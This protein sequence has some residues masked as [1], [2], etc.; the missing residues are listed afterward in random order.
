MKKIN[1][2]FCSFPDYSGNA[3]GLYEYIIKRNVSNFNLVWIVYNKDSVDKLKQIGIYAI[4]IGTDEFKEYISTTDIFF[5]THGNLTGDKTEKSLYVELWHGIGPKPIG[6]MTKNMLAQ[7]RVWYK[8]LEKRIDYFVTP[9]QFW[10]VLFSSM[11]GVNPDRVLPLG[12]PILDHI[13]NADG[14]K[15]LS[16]VLDTEV[17]KYNKIIYYLPTFRKGC[18]RECE[19]NINKNNIFNFFEYNE[20]E[21]LKYLKDNN[22]LLVL[23]R[24]PSEELKFS[25]TENENFHL[26]T[27]DMLAE[28]G[29]T[30]NEILNAADIM[31]TDYSSVGVEFVFLNK[32]VIYVDK[33]EEEYR[34]NRGIFFDNYEFWTQ[35]ITCSTLEGLKDIIKKLESGEIDINKCYSNLRKLWY[36]NLNDGG[37]ANIFD[38]FFDEN[39]NIRSE[40][41]YHKDI[42]T[43]LRKELDSVNKANEK[44]KETLE[45][46]ENEIKQVYNSKGWKFLERIR[47]IKKIFKK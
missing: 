47:K 42:E 27:D 25:Y 23:K 29:I 33:D 5:T 22:Y 21:L 2:T 20:E 17:N 31:I 36:D 45:E 26:I 44:I 41:T 9:S 39:G 1:I 7:D 43:Y 18:G 40:V 10:K 8:E 35:G 11:F 13:K 4:L 38:F 16:K 19:S 3:K 30:V 14:K 28:N 37:C 32:P 15:N 24:H 6:Y 12:L 34:N 46:K